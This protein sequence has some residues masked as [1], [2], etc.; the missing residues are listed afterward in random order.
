MNILYDF[1]TIQVKTGAGEYHRRVFFA[2]LDMLRKCGMED[3]RVYAL[4]DLRKGIAY[5]DLRPEALQDEV[6]VR[7]VDC[8]G[9]RIDTLAE[10]LCI[11]SFFIA[12][13]QYF[14]DYPEICNLRCRCLCVIH[15]IATEEFVHNRL[16]T[17]FQLLDPKYAVPVVFSRIQRF[18]HRYFFPPH[19]RH[20]DRFAETY[21]QVTTYDSY[22]Q[23]LN[24]L[25]PVVS[26]SRSNPQTHLV[27]VSEFSR[28]SL[29]YNYGIKAEDIQVLYSPER[30]TVQ[31]DE[32]QDE[33]LRR[34]VGEGRRYFLMTSAHIGQKN[35]RKVIAAYRKY[36]RLHPEVLLVTIG[37][38]QRVCDGHVDLPFLCDADLA[39]AYRNCHALVYPSYCEGFG[40]PPIECMRYGKPVLASNTT[41]IPEVLGDAPL[42]FCPF[43]ESEIFAAMCRLTPDNYRHYCSEAL[44][45]YQHVHQRQE[46]D[47]TT[48]VRM[49]L[50]QE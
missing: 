7:F 28:M 38:G 37:Y 3:V 21:L 18:C 30:L 42:Y 26:L 4:Y 8:S 49:I 40:Y 45:R 16:N 12:C 1:I 33:T 6:G 15:D 20:M 17:Y 5:E 24:L 47:L 13:A 27:T 31:A 41:S 44:K 29:V 9:K 43:Y 25:S 19:F 22:Q 23:L 2:M 34:L 50:C 46:A 39:N 35:P 32:I 14:T 36:R 10:E 11:D 48:L